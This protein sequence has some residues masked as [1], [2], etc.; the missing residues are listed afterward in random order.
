MDLVPSLRDGKT[1]WLA[2]RMHN[3][4]LSAYDGKGVDGFVDRFKAKL[5]EH[6]EEWHATTQAWLF[7]GTLSELFAINGIPFRKEDFVA[8]SPEGSEILSTKRLPAYLAAWAVAATNHHRSILRQ[9]KHFWITATNEVFKDAIEDT[10]NEALLRAKRSVEVVDLTIKCLEHVARSHN[11]VAIASWD[12]IVSL[13]GRMITAIRSLYNLSQEL[14]FDD[15]LLSVRKAIR[16]LGVQASTRLF[17]LNSWCPREIAIIGD[18]VEHDP[19][20]VL[21]CAQLRRNED[22]AD[23]S[24]CDATMCNA[25]QI[26]ESIYQTKH[27]HNGC[28]CEFL[29]LREEKVSS[30]STKLTKYISVPRSLQ[31]I[32]MVV[33]RDGRAHDQSVPL[34]G[35]EAARLASKASKYLDLQTNVRCVAISHVWVDGMGNAKENLLPECQ[36]SRLQ[37]PVYPNCIADD[38]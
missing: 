7:F 31:N 18:L 19:C 25:Y 2:V 4:E 1:A 20:T 26:D 23:H 16:D 9:Q 27:W 32:R 30:L 13:C 24:R 38:C 36:I 22:R 12:L 21:Y 34:I 10:G 8:R 37:V 15:R 5:L 17:R 3:S 11:I 28:D 6:P 33:W 14:Y 35:V 29:G